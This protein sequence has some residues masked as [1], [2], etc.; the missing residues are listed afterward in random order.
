MKRNE[1]I[2]EYIIEYLKMVNNISGELNIDNR[3]AIRALMNIT[4]PKDLQDDFYNYQ[5]DYLKS[6]LDE[7]TITDS[8]KLLAVN[9]IAVNEGDMTLIKA[10][11]IINCANYTLEGCKSALHS[12]LDNSIH[13]FAGLQLRRDCKKITEKKEI[14][15][16]NCYIT[17]GYN[18]PCKYIFHVIV[19]KP[20]EKITNEDKEVLKSCYLKALESAD[21][22]NCKTI[23]FPQMEFDGENYPVSIEAQIAY[24]VVTNYLNNHKDSD[25]EKVIFNVSNSYAYSIYEKVIQNKGKLNNFKL[26]KNLV[27]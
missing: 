6:L 19:N 2:E 5:N 4:D 23:V 13:S 1:E 3:L 14:K 11:A 12:C 21:D 18:L 9:K 22:Y 27:K 8:H 20:D 24:E 10:D 26:N 17:K 25:I 16:G 15:A 7:E